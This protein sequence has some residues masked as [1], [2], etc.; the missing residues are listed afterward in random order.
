MGVAALVRCRI[1]IREHSSQQYP[2][3]SEQQRS[4]MP[5]FSLQQL[6][7]ALSCSNYR[8]AQVLLVRTA[9]PSNCRVLCRGQ[10]TVWSNTKSSGLSQINE[11][12]HEL[13]IWSRERHSSFCQRDSFHRLLPLW[14]GRHRC[15]TLIIS[16]DLPFVCS[17]GS[18]SVSLTTRHA[19]VLVYVCFIQCVHAVLKFGIILNQ[20]SQMWGGIRD[21][22]G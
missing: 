20:Y 11:A 2:P 4:K 19:V 9:S 22:F 12:T 8:A 21:S 6:T 13:N 3:S 17:Q 10:L 16:E 5:R 18:E 7:S 1:T 15:D 14:R